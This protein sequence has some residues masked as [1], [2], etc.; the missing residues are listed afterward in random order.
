[1]AK[2]MNE[3]DSPELKKIKDQ[4]NYFNRKRAEFNNP[5]KGKPL[6]VGFRSGGQVV[7]S[8][9]PDNSK[10]YWSNADSSQVSEEQKA[11]FPSSMRGKGY[12]GYHELRDREVPP[13]APS[14]DSVFSQ[15]TPERYN[16]TSQAKLYGRV[17]CS[18]GKGCV[19]EQPFG[20][21][22]KSIAKHGHDGKAFT[23]MN[24]AAYLAQTGKAGDRENLQNSWNAGS[25]VMPQLEN[26]MAQGDTAKVRK[27]LENMQGF[28]P[29]Q[30][31]FRNEIKR[32][33]I[34]ATA[35][36]YSQQEMNQMRDA[37]LD[38][39]S[40]KGHKDINEAKRRAMYDPV[41]EKALS[42]FEQKLQNSLKKK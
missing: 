15:S 42:A 10:Y 35:K 9:S 39:S 12:T 2:N 17:V 22:G 13:P 28:K 37:G 29:G 19:V 32:D 4:T 6:P 30:Q 33:T 21:D 27:T 8:V 25:E 36:Y 1:M 26:M 38:V 3:L 5:G 11:G 23:Q 18:A 34:P 7:D 16:E 24:E 20:M 14:Q 31:I 41:K 40:F